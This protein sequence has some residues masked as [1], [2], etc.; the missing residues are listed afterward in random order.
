MM[1]RTLIRA[2][3]HWPM[4]QW[5]TFRSLKSREAMDQASGEELEAALTDV[6]F[7]AKAAGHTQH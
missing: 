3:A 5:T 4:R 1:K 6:K 2:R 7:L